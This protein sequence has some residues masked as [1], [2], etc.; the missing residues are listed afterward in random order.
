MAQLEFGGMSC[1][2]ARNALAQTVAEKRIAKNYEK[3]GKLIKTAYLATLTGPSKHIGTLIFR[4]P[5][6]LVTQPAGAVADALYAAA[7]DGQ[8][9]RTMY[10]A[11]TLRGT[12]QGAKQGVMDAIKALSNKDA[13]GRWNPQ[14][15]EA[16][17]NAYQLPE[18]TYNHALL[19]H[20]VRLVDVITSVRNKPFFEGAMRAS[21]DLQARALATREGLVGGQQF[22]DRVDQLVS[23][24]TNQMALQALEDASR[25]TLSNPNALERGFSALRAGLDRYAQGPRMLSPL[26][27]AKV[28]AMNEG[29][30]GD[31]VHERVH[32]L[33]S[34]SP[35]AFEQAV[36]VP[37]EAVRS[38]AQRAGQGL[39]QAGVLAMDVLT[40]FPRIT[41]NLT[42]AAVNL[43]PIGLFKAAL[44][45]I[46]QVP[47]Q[48]GAFAAQ[49][50]SKAMM[51]SAV[52]L[53]AGYKLAQHGLMTGPNPMNSATTGAGPTMV[54]LGSSWHDLKV[55]GPLFV[56][57]VF[58]ASFYEATQHNPGH[59]LANLSTA[60]GQQG[61]VMLRDNMIW[62]SISRLADAHTGNPRDVGYAVNNAIPI[63]PILQQ[64]AHA[65][66]PHERDLSS[67]T[68]AGATWNQFRSRIPGLRETLPEKADVTGS[69]ANVHRDFADNSV[70]GAVS[71]LMDPTRPQQDRSTAVTNELNRLGVN[72]KAPNATHKFPGGSVTL[73]P[74]EHLAA[75]QQLGPQLMQHL[76]TVMTNPGYLR[77]SDPLRKML[78]ERAAAV[79]R[80]AAMGPAFARAMGQGRFVSHGTPQPQEIGAP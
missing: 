60:A 36:D 50:F 12:L 71:T 64:L 47:G 15:P 5:E 68:F 27:R 66:D 35:K 61:L 62:S 25:Y 55:L 21:L 38:P 11:S 13:Q 9:S 65:T 6:A 1:A 3:A 17:G 24:P 29:L 32:Q 76:Q 18:V 48:R 40:P 59:L 73:S 8:R 2:Q 52:G 7:T 28:Q 67:K 14:D 53:W 16:M 80:R 69:T 39:S 63:P 58:G 79:S 4:A 77:A 46:H 34:L 45:T 20:A 41:T 75:Q 37:R 74:E 22:I 23:H 78:L 33:L 51:G 10:G 19:N 42:G 30:K 57:P 44:E 72:L 70:L 56:M 49:A 43:T 54:K 26:E 31:A